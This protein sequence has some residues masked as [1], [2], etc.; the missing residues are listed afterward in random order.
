MERRQAPQPPL[1]LHLSLVSHVRVEALVCPAWRA[2]AGDE[3]WVSGRGP[4]VPGHFWGRVVG[5]EA[6]DT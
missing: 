6:A 4:C 5:T 3:S 2:A 1:R